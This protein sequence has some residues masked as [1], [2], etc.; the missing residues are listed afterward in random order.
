M[1]DNERCANCDGVYRL[2]QE[3]HE[4]VCKQFKLLKPSDDE[5]IDLMQEIFAKTKGTKRQSYNEAAIRLY[6]LAQENERNKPRTF[7]EKDVEKAANWARENIDGYWTG[8]LNKKKGKIYDSRYGSY[9][10]AIETDKKKMRLLLASLGLEPAEQAEARGRKEGM[11]CL[12]GLPLSCLAPSDLQ[13]CMKHYKERIAEAERRGYEKG[14]T[15]AGTT[16][17]A[18]YAMGIKDGYAKGKA[19]ANKEWPGFPNSVAD[20]AYKKGQADLIEWLYRNWS[21][22]DEFK[23]KIEKK[24]SESVGADGGL[25]QRIGG[26]A[27]KPNTASSALKTGKKSLSLPAN[28]A[29]ET[30]LTCRQEIIRFGKC[31]HGGIDICSCRIKQKNKFEKSLTADQKPHSYNKKKYCPPCSAVLDSWTTCAAKKSK[32]TKKKDGE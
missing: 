29:P 6:R 21:W 32:P 22:T 13:F 15:K 30:P 2:H 24:V 8:K 31:K 17:T 7:S 28:P 14:L 1:S 11:V 3:N 12:D 4:S 20:V 19:D 18:N 26:N 5:I 27:V 23:A 10:D 25:R 9:D 16:N